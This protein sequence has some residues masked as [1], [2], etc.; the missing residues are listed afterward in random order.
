MTFWKQIKQLIDSIKGRLII[1]L[2]IAIVTYLFA[3]IVQPNIK[4]DEY[5]YPIENSDIIKTVHIIF[6]ENTGYSTA[7]DVKVLVTTNFEQ[8]YNGMKPKILCQILDNSSDFKQITYSC[9]KLA[10]NA[11][12]IITIPAPDNHSTAIEVSSNGE[13]VSDDESN[14]LEYIIVG[15]ILGVLIN[16]LVWVVFKTQRRIP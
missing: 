10:S 11:K 7:S 3:Y 1:A 2:I 13:I 5:E 8:R 4:Y 12:F 16:V 15:L 14:L 6:L 9:N